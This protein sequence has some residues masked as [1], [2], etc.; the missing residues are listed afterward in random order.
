MYDPETPAAYFPT[1]GTACIESAILSLP[2]D[3]D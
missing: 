2:T 3:G 1:L